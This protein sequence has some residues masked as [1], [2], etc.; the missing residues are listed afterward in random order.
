MKAKKI[1]KKL[2]RLQRYDVCFDKEDQSTQLYYYNQGILYL[3][4]DVQK[5]ISEYEN[6][7]KKKI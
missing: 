6:S 4:S 7:K 1:I 5:I 3:Y 2:K